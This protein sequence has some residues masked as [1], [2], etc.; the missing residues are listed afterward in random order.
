MCFHA[1]LSC[2]SLPPSRPIGFFL[3]PSACVFS[4]LALGAFLTFNWRVS[5][6]P[7]LLVWFFGLL[8]ACVLSAFLPRVS[9]WFPIRV[10]FSAFHPRVSFRP[11]FRVCL[12]GAPSAW[13][14]CH[15]PQF[16]SFRHLSRSP[17]G[18]ALFSALS[19]VTPSH[20]F[21]TCLF[22]RFPALF[23]CRTARFLIP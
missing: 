12:S 3:L 8:S 1:F 10:C 20:V 14:F 9:F 15:P 23:P 22:E 2:N 5:F 18:A 17:L 13:G 4:A 19:L 7:S 6:R 11:S 21:S 16:G